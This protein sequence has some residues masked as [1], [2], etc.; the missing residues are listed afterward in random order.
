MQQFNVPLDLTSV[1]GFAVVPCVPFNIVRVI[2]SR[3]VNLVGY[4]TRIA[5]VNSTEF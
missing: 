3:R 5:E 2:K 1:S 4:V